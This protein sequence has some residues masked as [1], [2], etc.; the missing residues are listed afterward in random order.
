MDWRPV[1]ITK[2]V[3]PEPVI[4]TVA[5]ELGGAPERALVKL[6]IAAAIWGSLDITGSQKSFG[7]L[8]QYSNWLARRLA[9][10]AAGA[11][12]ADCSGTGPPIRMR[13]PSGQESRGESSDLLLGKGR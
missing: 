8:A 6:S 10:L 11:D 3:D 9:Q 7:R 13:R 5:I 1:P 4:P 12:Q 2:R